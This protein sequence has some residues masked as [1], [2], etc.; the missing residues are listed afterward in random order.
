MVS[1]EVLGPIRNA[2]EFAKLASCDLR[3]FFSFSP[4]RKLV[5]TVRGKGYTHIRRFVAIPSCRQMRWLVPVGNTNGPVA[6]TQ[7]YAPYNW[8]ARSLKRILIR[9]IKMRWEGWPASRVLVAS[10]ELLP[11][12]VLVSTVTGESHPV[13]ALSIGRQASVRKLTVQVMRSNGGLLGY[14]KLP[15]TDAARERVKNEATVLER[16]WAFPELRDHIPQVLYA[17]NWNDSYVLF[18]SGLAGERGPTRFDGIHERFLAKLQNV[19]SGEMDAGQ[20]ISKVARKWQTAARELD[21]TWRSLGREVLQLASLGLHGTTL[22]CGIMHGDFA[23]WNT[24]VQN[25]ELLLF[26]WES[27]DWQAPLLWDVFHFH[28][29]TASS[30]GTTAKFRWPVVTEGSISSML[31]ILSSVCQFLQENNHTA[32]T[33]RQQLLVDQLTKQKAPL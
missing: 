33:L 18:E 28:L 9:M 15:L 25:N 11:L 8:A 21:A 22:R 16:L 13:L 30:L 1:G 7:L 3:P 4:S 26:D 6:G 14:I 27:A 29:Q 20:L 12:E 2:E 32:I 23:P 31:Y 10:R 17:G 24:R 19:H 5:E